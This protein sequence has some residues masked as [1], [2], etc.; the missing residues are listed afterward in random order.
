MIPQWVVTSIYVLG[1]LVIGLLGVI[2]CT[3]CVAAGHADRQDERIARLE[4]E[5][6]ELQIAL[7]EARA[8]TAAAETH[9]RQIQAL[10]ADGA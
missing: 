7:E 4:T 3:A 6:R 9:A 2:A 5:K 8:E 10:R 1:L